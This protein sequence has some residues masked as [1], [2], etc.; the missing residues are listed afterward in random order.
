M[1]QP[2]ADAYQLEILRDDGRV[3]CLL[4]DQETA[5]REVN[6]WIE[7]ERQWADTVAE[8]EQTKDLGFDLLNEQQSGPVF[9][10]ND[11]YIRR[12]TG[13]TID[14]RHETSIAYRFQEVSGMQVTKV[15]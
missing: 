15:I 13:L 14:G 12:L 10:P 3:L 4:V 9:D 8:S 6:A 7:H 2:L 11:F 1:M 5:E